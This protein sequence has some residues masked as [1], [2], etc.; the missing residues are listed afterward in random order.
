LP[1]AAWPFQPSERK[2]HPLSHAIFPIIRSSLA[3][4]PLLCKRYFEFLAETRLCP[5]LRVRGPLALP[6]G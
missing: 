4:P 3:G 1:C 2:F 6:E 5:T